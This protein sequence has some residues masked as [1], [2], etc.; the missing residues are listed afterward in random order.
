MFFNDQ[1][2]HF[3]IRDFLPLLVSLLDANGSDLESSLCLGRSD[4]VQGVFAQPLEKVYSKDDATGAKS[5]ATGF[6]QYLNRRIRLKFQ[7][8]TLLRNE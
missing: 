1:G 6:G 4:A 3:F 8:L 2:L 7:A 5:G